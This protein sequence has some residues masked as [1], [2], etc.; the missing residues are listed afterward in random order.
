MRKLE[1]ILGMIADVG[2]LAVAVMLLKLLLR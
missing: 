2:A 1:A